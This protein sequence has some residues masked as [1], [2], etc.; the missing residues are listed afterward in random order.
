MFKRFVLAPDS[1]KGTLEAAEVCEILATAIRAEVPDAQIAAIPMTD[2]GEGMTAA[3]LRLVGGTRVE[4]DVTGPLGASVRGFYG[5][6]DDGSA[7]I[8]MAAAAGLPLAG[9]VR[10]PLRATT[11]GV[12]ELIRHAAAQGARRILLGLGGSATND[13]G[14]GM[15]AALGW[16]FLDEDGAELAP[17]AEN[18]NK[19]ARILPPDEQLPCPVIAACDVRNVLLGDDGATAVYGP[20]KGVTAQLRP[21]LE[22]GLARVSGM[23]EDMLDVPLQNVPGSGAAGGMGAGVLAFLGGTLKPGIEMLLDAVDFDAQLKTAD[24]VFTGEGC[25]DWQ[26]ANGKV[27]MGVGMR[28]KRAGVPCIALCGSLGEGAEGMYGCGV[29]ACFSAIR[30]ET[31]FSRIRETCRD[32]LDRLA[33]SVLRLMNAAQG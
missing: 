2:G 4:L 31:D 15:A 11:W 3:Y 5:L 23:L 9:N 1:F 10:D 13:M 22:A 29:T 28:C 26:S 16:R 33:R 8:E 24:V 6:L 12:G 14:A 21:A 20:Q 32:D 17:L 30:G 18:L 25:M 27:P 19:V 7:V